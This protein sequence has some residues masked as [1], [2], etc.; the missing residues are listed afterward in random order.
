MGNLK[1]SLSK[2]LFL[3]G[4]SLG[5]IAVCDLHLLVAGAGVG[6]LIPAVGICQVSPDARHP[7]RNVKV[8]VLFGHH[9]KCRT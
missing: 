9:L 4:E 8:A 3:L 5:D 2:V 1:A 7:F 6:E